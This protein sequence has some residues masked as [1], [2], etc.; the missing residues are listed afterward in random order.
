M[1]A[2]DRSCPALSRIAF[3][4]RLI[5]LMGLP[6]RLLWSSSSL[7]LFHFSERSFKAILRKVVRK[8]VHATI[9][10]G[11]MGYDQYTAVA[12]ECTF[13]AFL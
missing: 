1:I 13:V 11:N 10:R 7:W 12:V 2:E 6:R 5:F 4:S 9:L 8:I 3:T